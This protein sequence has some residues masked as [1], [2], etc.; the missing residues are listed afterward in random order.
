MDGTLTTSLSFLQALQ[1]P[2]LKDIILIWKK[3]VDSEPLQHSAVN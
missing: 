1:Y 2:G 3:Q